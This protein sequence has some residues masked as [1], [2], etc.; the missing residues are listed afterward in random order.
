MTA[1][2]ALLLTAGLAALLTALSAVAGVPAGYFTSARDEVMQQAPAS[3]GKVAV[4]WFERVQVRAAHDSSDQ[5]QRSLAARLNLKTPGQYSA[6]KQILNLRANRSAASYQEAFSEALHERYQLLIE[7]NRQQQQVHLA[8]QQQQLT[9]KA[10][11][12]M[13]ALAGSSEFRPSRL[14]SEE[15]HLAA[16]KEDHHL[17]TLRLQRTR[18]RFDALLPAVHARVVTTQAE[19]DLSDLLPVDRLAT[20]PETGHGDDDEPHSAA[21]RLAL[22]DASIAREQLQREQGRSGLGL[23][24][25][26]L[27]HASERNN[28]GGDYRLTVGI[29]FPI[30][31][32]FAA[33]ERQI[34]YNDTEYQMHQ[35]FRRQARERARA[36]EELELLIDEYRIYRNQLADLD[37][38]L[39]RH[40]RSTPV[41]LTLELKREQLNTRSR[42]IGLEADIYRRYIDAIHLRGLLAVEPLR[43]WLVIGRPAL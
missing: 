18:R 9:E 21:L 12:S 33:S 35:L 11:T 4:P 19:I 38:R 41:T 29:D 3:D 2:S 37:A 7:L 39:G 24:F 10:V 42:L 5:H 1:V 8:A 31:R 17:A 6:E 28:S 36:D 40:N 13:R 34:Q 16:L 32:T 15:L 30:G 26:E 14:Q 43:N 22:L 25:L 20:L 23:R 27:R